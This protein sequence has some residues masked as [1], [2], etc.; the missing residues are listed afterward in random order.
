[1]LIVSYSAKAAKELVEEE[2]DFYSCMSHITRKLYMSECKE[3]I[4]QL[5]GQ[6]NCTNKKYTVEEEE[7]ESLKKYKEIIT[8]R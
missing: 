6:I 4:K 2:V 5:D 8:A 3:F 7:L 1:M